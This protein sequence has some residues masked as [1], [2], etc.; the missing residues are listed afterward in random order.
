[1]T[2]IGLR[3]SKLEAFT[4]LTSHPRNVRRAEEPNPDGAV[5][6]CRLRGIVQ[7]PDSRNE[8]DDGRHG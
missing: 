8:A 5:F 7:I 4:A 3:E 2:A 6:L 1:M